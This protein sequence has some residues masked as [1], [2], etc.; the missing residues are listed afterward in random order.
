M[1]NELNDPKTNAKTYCS[2]LKKF[3]NGGKIPVI[4]TVLVNGKLVLEFK[5][6]GN[7]FNK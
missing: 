2:I 5:E 6:K 1:E 3:F 7:K 4:L